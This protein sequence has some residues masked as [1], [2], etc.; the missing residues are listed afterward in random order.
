MV[1]HFKVEWKLWSFHNIFWLTAHTCSSGS[2]FFVSLF[3]S[4]FVSHY[5]PY[6]IDFSMKYI[7]L[8]ILSF[9]TLSLK[10]QE[11]RHRR[12]K[13][14][15]RKFIKSVVWQNDDWKVAEKL[16]S[17]EELRADRDGNTCSSLPSKRSWDASIVTSSKLRRFL[18]T[19]GEKK[20]TKLCSP[21][22]IALLCPLSTI[23]LNATFDSKRVSR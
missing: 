11:K 17:R 10:Y 16:E 21:G 4:F 12:Q 7:F 5:F 19:N 14:T 6:R 23:S 1:L 15:I 22:G 3:S 13:Q 2:P 9:I 20:I 8:P 18:I